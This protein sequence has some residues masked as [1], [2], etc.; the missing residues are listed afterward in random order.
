M[1]VYIIY[2]IKQ[3][4][5]HGCYLVNGKE[6]DRGKSIMLSV[7]PDNN[8]ITNH[9]VLHGDIRKIMSSPSILRRRREI[10][11]LF[12]NKAFRYL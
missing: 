3:G 8:E 2:I 1:D 7:S 10:L 4:W 12:P 6:E 9:V 5:N 11:N